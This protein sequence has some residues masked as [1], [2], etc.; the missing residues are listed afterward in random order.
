MIFVTVGTQEFQ[1]NRLLEELDVLIQKGV[2][3]S[4]DIYAQIGHSTYTPRNYKFVPFVN[5]S[6]FELLLNQ[7]SLV[8]SHG[9]VGSIVTALRYNKKVIVVP[10]LRKFKEHV[11]D[12][13]LEI[14][15]HF[16]KERYVLQALDIE[17]LKSIIDDS[18]SFSPNP[19]TSGNEGIIK[20]LN[21]YIS[22]T[23]LAIK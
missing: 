22:A 12:H 11:D 14:V 18:Y 5:K 8:I 2:M 7:C 4:E 3:Q 20:L 9:G 19:Y 13:Q 10:R 1:F 6:E 21:D 17:N 15:S 16:A 23:F